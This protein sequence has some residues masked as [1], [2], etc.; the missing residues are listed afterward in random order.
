MPSRPMAAAAG[1]GVI[2][3][4]DCLG[5][6]TRADTWL[7][8]VAGAVPTTERI[9]LDVAPVSFV[10][11]YG[12]A[13][14]LSVCQHLARERGRPVQ[15]VGLQEH[16]HA[17]LRRVDFFKAGAGAVVADRP[18]RWGVEIPRSLASLNV[19]ELTVVRSL[20]EVYDATARALRIL[21]TWLGLDAGVAQH[22]GCCIA[23][24]CEN[25]IEHSRDS[26]VL[27]AQKYE[28]AGWTEV[29]LA[30][31][32]LGIGIRQSLHTAYAGL[33]ETPAGWIRRAVAGLS[34]RGDRGGVGLSEIR[35]LA[36]QTGGSLLIR[37]GAGRAMYA[38]GHAWYSDLQADVGGLPGTQLAVT[39][40][41]M[42][43]TGR[44][45]EVQ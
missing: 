6:P 42:G 39:L 13:V 14:L 9:D 24:A 36:T 33:D 16:V 44:R 3:L 21:T 25:V 31:A 32:D 27:V 29:Q 30:I 11:P 34:C 2:R 4:A 28:F 26:G 41:S 15:L 17:Y 45:T 35:R 19:L 18:L 1:V 20:R 12:A 40:R 7:A 22:V 43:G 5:S 23:E 10:C 38:P 8:Q 37:S